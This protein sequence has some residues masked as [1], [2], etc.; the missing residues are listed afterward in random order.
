MSAPPAGEENL[1]NLTLHV[2]STGYFFMYR[3][4]STGDSIYL[5][6]LSTGGAKNVPYK[7][8]FSDNAQSFTIKKFHPALPNVDPLTFNK[9]N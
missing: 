7:I 9:Q 2:A 5:S 1:P 4:N 3:L 8:T 6:D